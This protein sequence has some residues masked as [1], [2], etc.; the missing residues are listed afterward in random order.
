[1]A[2]QLDQARAEAFA[3]KMLG[4]L[5]SGALALMTSVGHR[6]GLFDAMAAAP[7]STSA[8]IAALAGLNERYVREWL[9]AM[10]TGGVVEHD[11]ANGEYLLPGEHAAS[12]TRAAA[13]DNIAAFAQYIAVLG[14]VEDRIVECFSNGGGVPY[15]SY[16]RFHEVM[17]EDSGQTVVAALNDAILPLA[18]GLVES[19]TRGID[20]LDV[21]CGSGGALRGDTNAT[22][23]FKNTIVANSTGGDCFGTG[24]FTTLGHNIDSDKTCSLTDANDKPGVNPV[25]GPLADNGGSTQTHALL[26]G[27][28]ALD[29]GDDPAAPAT[30]QRGVFRPQGG[31]S[32]IGAFELGS[33]PVPSVSALGLLALAGL[34][35]GLFVR[36]LRGT[37]ARV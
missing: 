14:G 19:L 5:N 22:Y 17:A 6:T 32:D 29:A 12:L 34:T 16:P 11:P 3:D 27:S 21:G 10:V 9:G 23:T 37:R 18:P 1:M 25:L 28:P 20:V 26:S 24:T 4:M 13:P 30:D 2:E 35:L 33:L 15:S 31:A 8:Q 7:A 36:K